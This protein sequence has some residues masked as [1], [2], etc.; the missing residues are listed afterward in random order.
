M[1]IAIT[2]PYQF[3][4][5]VASAPGN[6]IL[7]VFLCMSLLIRFHSGIFALKRQFSDVSK[8]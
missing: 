6:Q 1:V 7:A 4:V 2:C 3:R 8:S 5:P